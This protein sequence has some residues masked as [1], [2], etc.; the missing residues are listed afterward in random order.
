M[1]KLQISGLCS[2]CL[3]SPHCVFLKKA[4]RPVLE[5]GEFNPMVKTE[6]G[7]TKEKKPRP[8]STPE[9]AKSQSREYNGLCRLCDKKDTCEYVKD[10]TGVWHC[11]EYV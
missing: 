11:E 9:P 8:V 3:N 1:K 5:C 7:K 4:V 10:R 2:C 6:S